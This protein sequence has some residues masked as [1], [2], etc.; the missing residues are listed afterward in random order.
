[1]NDTLVIVPTKNRPEH[2]N[3][4]VQNLIMQDGE[5]DLF[6]G[7]MSDDP[8]TLEDN[9]F[10]RVGLE[11]MRSLGHNYYVQRVTG[12]NQLYGYNA[13]MKFAHDAGYKYCLGGD[14]DII[15][16]LGWLRKGRQNMVDDPNL[17]ICAGVTLNPRYSL[18]SQT[19]GIGLPI[20]TINHPDF[21]GKIDKADYYHCIFVPPTKE[22]RY[23]E[24]IYG[25]F[26]FRPDD[27]VNVGGFPSFLSP[28][29][30]RGEMM[31]ETAIFFSGKKIMLDPTMI[32][33]H[34]QCPYGGL[35]Y[36]PDVKQQYFDSDMAIWQKWVVRRIPKVEM[37]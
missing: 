8:K 31:L 30:Y 16:E 25:G 36:P 24:V 10:L 35:R 28:L 22:P 4:L 19:I 32:S 3:A 15:Y 17:G 9:A 14:D 34:Y 18:D 5:F 27:A 13:G 20:E 33:W 29:G 37:P 1:M 21:A 7:D 2:V 11:R 23:Y 12:T 26:F 6:I